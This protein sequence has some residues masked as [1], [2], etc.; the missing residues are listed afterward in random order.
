MQEVEVTGWGCSAVW[1][2]AAGIHTVPSLAT[3]WWQVSVPWLAWALASCACIVGS[4]ELCLLPLLGPLQG[5]CYA[6]PP[7]CCCLLAGIS[8][9]A[10]AEPCQMEWD[11][12]RECQVHR[13]E[14]SNNGLEIHESR[15]DA[16]TLDSMVTEGVSEEV[17]FAHRSTC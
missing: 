15:K 7:L 14:R 11:R 1:I 17:T 8:L 16:V 3:E 13:W 4:N 12:F 9:L 10:A 5:C 6:A 2:S